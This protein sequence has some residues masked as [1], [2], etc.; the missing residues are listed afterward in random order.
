MDAELGH[1]KAAHWRNSALL[2]SR[3]DRVT[4]SKDRYHL[5]YGC[6]EDWESYSEE[7]LRELKVTVE[8]ELEQEDNEALEA[9][10]KLG[11]ISA[12]NKLLSIQAADR[13]TGAEASTTAEAPATETES[14]IMARKMETLKATRQATL[15]RYQEKI[16]Q[17]KVVQSRALNLRGA[18]LEFAGPYIKAL[19]GKLK[20]G[21]NI[22]KALERLVV[23]TPKDDDLP[24][25]ITSMEDFDALYD[26]AMEYAVRF[27]CSEPTLAG[28]TSKKRKTKKE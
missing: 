6:P 7:E 28:P 13:S 23:D 3:G 19:E 24:K 4:G 26:Q 8:A 25:L 11:S 5:E 20:K 22:G 17:L 10:M 15:L 1:H 12:R 9:Q 21:N 27:G 2:P 18:D 14:Q 16:V